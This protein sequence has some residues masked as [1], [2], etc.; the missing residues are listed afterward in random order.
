MSEEEE[1]L[2]ME[3]TDFPWCYK[4]NENRCTT[5][6]GFSIA[7][8]FNVGKWMLFYP[9]SKMN[10]SWILA[11]KLFDNNELYGVISM[12]CST[13][14]KN[15]RASSKNNG[16]IILYC[17]DS[18]NES[19]IMKIGK[20][21]LNKFKYIENPTIF[22]KPNEMTNNGTRATGCRCNHKYVLEN[23]LYKKMQ[24]SWMDDDDY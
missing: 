2:P 20:N 6:F 3:I 5:F 24:K 15:P 18:D 19:E 17:S 21:I 1:K 10:D 13:A 16:I 11:K 23:E 14:Y 7:P 22:Y 4:S 8:P 12:K 9:N